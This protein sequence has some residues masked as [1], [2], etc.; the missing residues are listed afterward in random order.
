MWWH[1]GWG[2]WWFVMPLLTVAFW[3]AVIWV[4]VSIV[5]GRPDPNR[6]ANARPARPDEIL[7][8]RY[9][10]GEIDD[11]EYRRRLD[12][13]RGGQRPGDHP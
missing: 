10:R 7:A 5:R 6:A 3:A 1:D 11:D 2:G 8:Q 4:V 12:T 9:A 13:L